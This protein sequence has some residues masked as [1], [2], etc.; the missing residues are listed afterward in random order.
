MDRNMDRISTLLR[1]TSR[2]FALSIEGLPGRLG[3]EI[4]VS[5]LLLRVSDYIEDHGSLPPEEKIRLLGMWE[6]AL[7][8]PDRV[9]RFLETISGVPHR[10][11]DP[12]ASLV[13]ECRTLL[14][15]LE[16][17]SEEQA[18]VIRE[19]VRETT[20]GMARWQDKGPRVENEQELDDY[21]HQV[22]GLVGYLVTDLFSIHYP[23]VRRR[24]HELMPLAREFGLALQTV[25]VL[26]GLRKDY[27]RGWVFVPRT[28]VAAHGL[29]DVDL[30]RESEQPRAMGVVNDLI[31]KAERHLQFGL[32]YVRLIPRHLHRL[33][34]ACIWPLLFA[35]KT[36][37]ISRGN[38]AVLNGEVKI[39][40]ATVTRI[41]RDTT[42]RG[43][44]NA[45]IQRYANEL[46]TSDRAV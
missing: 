26:R 37:A 46:L 36:I 29:N 10:P 11:G 17:F 7:E 41:V 16:S 44:S 23:E 39:S 21:M 18:Y 3:E 40:R 15:A 19:R 32:T 2:T 31:G 28:F 4:A 1:E 24:H 33:R 30:F 38:P 20:R 34:L 43:W 27:E 8:R 25:N 14:D 13:L 22:A 42:I 35:A 6:A 12:E 45:W 9:E 5:Y